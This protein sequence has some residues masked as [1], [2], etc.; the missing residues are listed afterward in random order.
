MGGSHG[1]LLS[2]FLSL[3]VWQCVAVLPSHAPL[4]R[5]R[6]FSFGYSLILFDL[7]ASISII[8]YCVILH[9]DFILSKIKFSSLDCY[10]C[11]VFGP[12]SHLPPLPLFPFHFGARGPTRLL[13]LVMGTDGS[14]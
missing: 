6:P 3:A 13:P 14:R 4:V 2:S 10:S 8:L 7:L 12:S 1:I 9:S 11:S 5:S